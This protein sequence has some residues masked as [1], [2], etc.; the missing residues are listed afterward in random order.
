MKVYLLNVSFLA[1]TKLWLLHDLG[2]STH[3]LINYRHYFF[4]T[5]TSGFAKPQAVKYRGS[6][7][8]GD[9][10]FWFSGKANTGRDCLLLQFHL[11][12]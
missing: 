3:N 4:S 11:S 2:K 10:K 8:H 1:C 7:I 6:V 9:I 12:F 5:K